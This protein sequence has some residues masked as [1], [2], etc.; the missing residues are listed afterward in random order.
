MPHLLEWKSWQKI[1]VEDY[2]CITVFKFFGVLIN[3]LPCI[4]GTKRNHSQ[5]TETT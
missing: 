2:T 4:A 1:L 3:L 5:L